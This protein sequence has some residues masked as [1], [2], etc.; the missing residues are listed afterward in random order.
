MFV[1]IWPDPRTYQ[2]QPL[3]VESRGGMRIRSAACACR[4]G[5]PN[6]PEKDRRVAEENICGDY[7]Q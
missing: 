2:V 1:G 4:K 5:G 3:V 6:V 7:P